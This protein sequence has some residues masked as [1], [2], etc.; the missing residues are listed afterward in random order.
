MQL[1]SSLQLMGIP[2][3]GPLA[4]LCSAGQAIRRFIFPLSRVNPVAFSGNPPEGLSWT[5]NR[6]A[7]PGYHAF[8]GAA[9]GAM[10]IGFA[11][12][13]TASLGGKG[14]NVS[15]LN[16]ALSDARTALAGGNTTAFGSAMRSFRRDLGAKVAAGTIGR[17]VIEDY[18]KTLTGMHPA[19]GARGFPLRG[20]R[21]QVR[22]GR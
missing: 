14:Y 15:D 20:M 8:R 1:L 6:S 11:E 17:M 21:I 9:P 13:L 3:V 2:V 4:A 5:A 18:L 22:R 7:L 10:A 19:A 16:G 12:N